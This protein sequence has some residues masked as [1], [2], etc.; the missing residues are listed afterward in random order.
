MSRMIKHFATAS[1]LNFVKYPLID[2]LVGAVFINIED[3]EERDVLTILKAYE[4]IDQMTM[5]SGKLFKKLNETVV[6][7]ALSSKADVSLQFL[8]NYLSIF[9]DL[10]HNRDLR[11]DQKD[12]MVKLLEEKIAETEEKGIISS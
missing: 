9:S 5:G 3:V 7:V 12:V 1:K 4:H 6:E 2:K 11:P 8:I 10:P